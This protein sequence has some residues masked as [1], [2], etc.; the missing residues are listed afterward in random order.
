MKEPMIDLFSEGKMEL[1]FHDIEGE[2]IKNILCKSLMGLSVEGVQVSVIVTDN[3]AIR[4]INCRYR[5]KDRATDVI[6]FAYR[7]DPFP[8]VEQDLEEL[9]DIYL[10]LERALEQSK[11][12]E[13]TLREETA[14]LLVHGLLHLLGYDHERSKEDERIMEQKEEEILRYIADH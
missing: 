1:P 9:G 6:S 10:S 8:E 5:N 2:Y 4:E 14:R 13:V 11:E 12:Y 3:D 7:E